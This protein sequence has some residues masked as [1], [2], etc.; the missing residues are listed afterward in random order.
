MRGAA[1]HARRSA[2]VIGAIAL[3]ALSATAA[4][5]VSVTAV[6]R[7]FVEP[8]SAEAR[9][10]ADAWADAA[11][12]RA[13][14]V[15]STDDPDGW[16]ETLAVIEVGGALPHDAVTDPEGSLLA[17]FGELGRTEPP[18]QATIDGDDSGAPPVIRGR[19]DSDDGETW[20]VALASGGPTHA[21]VI[22]AVQ[23]DE[24]SLY[25]SRFDDVVARLDGAA[26]PVSAFRIAR[27]RI[28]S[29]SAWLMFAAL[30]WLVIA[31]V[32]NE[33]DA[34][35]RSRWVAGS[36]AFAAVAAFAIAYL[37]LER[38]ADALTLAGFSRGWVATEAALG[39]IGAAI[40]SLLVGKIRHAQTRRIQSAPV[41]GVYGRRLAPP[42]PTPPPRDIVPARVD[43]PS[44]LTPAEEVQTPTE[45][46]VRSRP[47]PPP[48]TET[49]VRSHPPPPP[50]R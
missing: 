19:F 18:R 12:G 48:R 26:P 3:Y 41:G 20:F 13:T 45:V 4:A 11:G 49:T 15:F 46:S 21:L 14:Q 10:R 29:A 22:M 33:D 5:A 44:R 24:A 28:G 25:A 34:G 6:P 9:A 30:A 1:G 50:R 27:W 16:S 43:G 8:A 42:R 39:G 7:G 40:V 2:P 32:R 47:P 35:E 37:L 31:R 38:S 23:T 36:C 17:A